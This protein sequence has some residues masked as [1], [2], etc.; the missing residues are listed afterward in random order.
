MLL[1]PTGTDGV[2]NVSLRD[3]ADQPPLILHEQAPHF[4]IEHVLSGFPR[5]CIWLNDVGV[6]RH[7]V[8]HHRALEQSPSRPRVVLLGRSLQHVSSRHHANDVSREI[9]DWQS[10]HPRVRQRLYE[11]TDGGFRRNCPDIFLHQVRY[12]HVRLLGYAGFRGNCRRPPPCG[13]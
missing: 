5:V 2:R 1:Q 12:S 7:D 10:G 6:R 13:Q 3:D 4:G 11:L 8:A 9:H